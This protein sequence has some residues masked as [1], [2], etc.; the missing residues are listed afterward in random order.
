MKWYWHYNVRMAEYEYRDVEKEIFEK[1]DKL[2]EEGYF[3]RFG[4]DNVKLIPGFSKYVIQQSTFGVDFGVSS[5]GEE[6]RY[7]SGVQIGSS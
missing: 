6:L 7:F 3:A 1:L 2:R 5:L 4:D